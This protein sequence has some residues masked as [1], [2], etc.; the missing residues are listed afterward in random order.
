M[1]GK[2]AKE[3]GIKIEQTVVEAEG[4]CPNCQEVPAR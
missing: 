3:T 1:L 2:A 4:I